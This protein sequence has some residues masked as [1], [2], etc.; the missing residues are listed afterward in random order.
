MKTKIII[1][2]VLVFLVL[3]GLSLLGE[4]KNIT[5]SDETMQKIAQIQWQ[6][7]ET[8]KNI[9]FKTDEN[10]EYY[11]NVDKTA[12]NDGV[13]SLL[14]VG[15]AEEIPK[16]LRQ[17]QNYTFEFEEG[18]MGKFDIRRFVTRYGYSYRRYNVYIDG[19]NVYLREDAHEGDPYAFEEVIN[20]IYQ[21][22]QGK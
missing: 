22:Q 3:F 18:T 9:G 7:E 8:L 12:S 6:N 14:R 17:Y 4:N 5:L 13:V 16:G 1:A 21:K 11:L 19:I 2:V 15:K 20:I 10:G